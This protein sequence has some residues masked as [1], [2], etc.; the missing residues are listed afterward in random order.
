MDNHPMFDNSFSPDS[1][2]ERMSI[3]RL[4]ILNK[5]KPQQVIDYGKL[6]CNET[7]VFLPIEEVR[8]RNLRSG[9][10]DHY[11]ITCIRNGELDWLWLGQFGTTNEEKQLIYPQV[12][13]YD[14]YDRLDFLTGKTLITGDAISEYVSPWDGCIYKYT[15][16]SQ[17][18]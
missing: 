4:S 13:G 9:G 5:T 1:P 14:H 8:Y 7:I 12:K 18:M 11:F 6:H 3:D 2:R 15:A 16:I 17:L 10:I